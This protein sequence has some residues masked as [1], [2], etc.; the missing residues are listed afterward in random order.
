MPSKSYHRAIETARG[1]HGGKTCTGLFVRPH[2]PFI[3]EVIDRLGCRS[4]LD[5]GCGKGQQYN[6]IMPKHSQTLEQYWGL[7]VTKYDPAVE[8]FAREP[9]GR[10]DLVICTHTLGTIPVGDRGWVI[11]RLHALAV[12]AIY[13]SE[14]LGDARK[15]DAVAG[16]WSAEDWTQALMRD[17]DIE[18]TLATRVVM[19]DGSK[20]TRHRRLRGDE[21]H[22]V[23][24]PADV[25]ALNH[26]WA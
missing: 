10:W 3:K 20:I 22:T 23:K 24:W 7:P 18:V 15:W 19:D 6:W 26:T 21:W 5:Y 8:Q 1:L 4:A 25:R 17:T 9:V 13:V 12:K 11:D 14:R 2:A 16:E